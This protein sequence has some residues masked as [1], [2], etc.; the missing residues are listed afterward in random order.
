MYMYICL[1]KLAD[2]IA[3][4]ILH[5]LFEISEQQEY[6]TIFLLRLFCTHSLNREIS[7]YVSKGNKKIKFA[8]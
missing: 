8:L 6:S 7:E 1:V 5:C 4:F 2:R 3:L